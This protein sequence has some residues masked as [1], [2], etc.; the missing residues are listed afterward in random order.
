MC[1]NQTGVA[2]PERMATLQP[3]LNFGG[4]G[5]NA[6][7]FV[8]RAKRMGFALLIGLNPSIPPLL[9]LLNIYCTIMLSK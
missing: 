3:S 4:G 7:L 1:H 9:Y 8:G 2:P 5:R 6:F